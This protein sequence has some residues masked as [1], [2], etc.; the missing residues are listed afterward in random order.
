MALAAKAKSITKFYTKDSS[1]SIH[2][3]GF[4][5]GCN[6]LVDWLKSHLPRSTAGGWVKDRLPNDRTKSVLVACKSGNNYDV[7][8]CVHYYNDVTKNWYGYGQSFS[9]YNVTHWMPL[10][11]PPT[12][13]SNKK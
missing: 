9:T 7:H 13:T 8:G 4:V 1:T 11:S 2:Q 6:W 12:E 10:P 3:D 5:D